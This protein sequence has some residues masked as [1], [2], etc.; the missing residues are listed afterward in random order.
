[1]Y[2]QQQPPPPAP[3]HGDNRGPQKKQNILDLSYDEYVQSFAAVKASRM[4]VV[5]VDEAGEQR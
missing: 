1:M 3:A 4:A 2:Q 5:A